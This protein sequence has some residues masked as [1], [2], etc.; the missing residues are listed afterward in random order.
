[1]NDTIETTK[2]FY[3]F[4]EDELPLNITGKVFLEDFSEDMDWIFPR[5]SDWSRFINKIDRNGIS[6]WFEK[7]GKY[8]GLINIKEVKGK[9]GTYTANFDKPK[10]LCIAK[11]WARAILHECQGIEFD[12]AY[13]C[14]YKGEY[15][16]IEIFFED[17]TAF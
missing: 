16:G 13:E 11:V 8:Y 1:M 14:Y 2:S 9:Y 12:L 10:T 17:I 7:N 3:S 4:I 6:E 15:Q 5:K